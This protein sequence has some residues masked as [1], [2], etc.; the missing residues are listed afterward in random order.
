MI[1]I[2]TLRAC[3]FI[4]STEL[5]WNVFPHLIGIPILQY[6][7]LLFSGLNPALK[8]SYKWFLSKGKIFIEW[9]SN[10]FTSHYIEHRRKFYHHFLDF[11]SLSLL[12]SLF[13]RSLWA[14][15][16]ETKLLSMVDIRIRCRGLKNMGIKGKLL[17][18]MK[19]SCYFL[20]FFWHLKE[21]IL[22]R[23]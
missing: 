16:S 10:I 12:I 1:N 4:F 22:G 2:A 21:R 14:E 15:L 18:W 8:L 5:L 6:C 20:V 3:L 13:V 9:K 17:K 23:L 7:N 19:F 11:F